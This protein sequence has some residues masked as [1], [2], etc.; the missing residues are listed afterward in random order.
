MIGCVVV[1]PLAGVV[2]N[3]SFCPH[4]R[5][6]VSPWVQYKVQYTAPHES[7]TP[8]NQSPWWNKELGKEPT[9]PTACERPGEEQWQGQ[10]VVNGMGMRLEI[11][12]KSLDTSL[13]AHSAMVHPA[14]KNI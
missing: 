2:Q 10:N 8:H 6:Q 13:L 14:C 3:K 12:D 7:L 9:E 5:V 4:I 11:I 1:L